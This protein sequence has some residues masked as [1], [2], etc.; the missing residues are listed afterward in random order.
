MAVP[1]I[2]RAQRC[3]I[4]TRKS[5]ENLWD[6]EFNSIESQ[7]D[8]CSAYITCQHHKRWVQL[9]HSYDDS[10]ASG[11]TLDRP[12]L[13]HLLRDIECG[14]IDV[15]V[16]YKM[17]RLTRSLADFIRLIEV[18]DRYHVKFVSVTQ[19][20]D[21]S[22]SMGRLVLNILLTFAQFERELISDRIRDKVAAMKR[23]GKRLGGNPPLGYDVV[24]RRLVVN[25]VEAEQ[26]RDI[27]RRFLEVGSCRALHRELRAEGMRSKVFVTRSGKVRG[28]GPISDA[29][30]HHILGNPVYAGRVRH[31]DT[32]YPGEHEAIVDDE[33]WGAAQTLRDQRSRYSGN[34]QPT[35]NFLRGLF[36]DSHGRRM[37]AIG[38]RGPSTPYRYYISEQSR[39]AAREGVK[40]FSIRADHFEELVLA[41]VQEAL[42]DREAIRAA[43]LDLGRHGEDLDRLP[44]RSKAAC[45]NL[46]EANRERQREILSSII[47]EGE[48]SR[49]RL[50]LVFRSSEVIRFVSWD[51]VGLFEGDRAAWSSNEPTFTVQRPLEEMRYARMLVMPIEPIAPGRRRPVKLSLVR[52]VHSA[53]RAQALL[54]RDRDLPV[55]ALARRFGC[56]PA[57]FCRL[58]RLNYL[59]PDI[60]AAILAG[61]QPEDL[62]RTRLLQGSLPLDWDLQRRMFGFPARS[63][64]KLYAPRDKAD[65]EQPEHRGFERQ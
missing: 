36:H 22:D 8:I 26:I 2:E 63:D 34:L 62:T 54:D 17:D 57:N 6:R 15:V 16:I 46:V 29:A 42:C 1:T 61:A 53:R 27:Y 35:P 64:H 38:S 20:F 14:E 49:H 39:W 12:A 48:V 43:L 50:V 4:Y 32:T 37:V 55:D 11:G 44:R 40:R 31:K 9:S 33:T 59:A 24:D 23:R 65:A 41:A 58:L 30:I 7:R 51:G 18:L 47:V 5:T 25:P 21:T 45:A 13:Q 60:I 56:R 28:G 3:A 10:G 19:A 52:L